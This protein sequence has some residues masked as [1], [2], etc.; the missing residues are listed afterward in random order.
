MNLRETLVRYSLFFV[1]S[2]RRYRALKPF[3]KSSWY[4]TDLNQYLASFIKS[5]LNI[6]DKKSLQQNFCLRMSSDRHR[7]PLRIPE[8]YRD[9]RYTLALYKYDELLVEERKYEYLACIGFDTDVLKDYIVVRQIQGNPGKGE[10][11]RLFKWERILLTILTDWAKKSGFNQIRVIEAKDQNWYRIHRAKQM[12]MHYDVTA[13]RS[14]F[15][16]NQSIGQYIKIL[17]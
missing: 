1:K 4:E 3:I 12:F 15:A 8:P 14:G 10:T 11:L 9:T 13:R 6:N 5:S 16:F 2:S 7:D 17:T